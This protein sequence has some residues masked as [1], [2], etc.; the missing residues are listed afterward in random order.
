[1]ERIFDSSAERVDFEQIAKALCTS[2][3][4]K[5]IFRFLGL[6]EFQRTYWPVKVGFLYIEVIIWQSF[7][8]TSTSRKGKVGGVWWNFA[9][10]GRASREK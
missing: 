2:V 8:S 7:F 4:I 1:M 5:F 6:K 3:D 9:F 10:P